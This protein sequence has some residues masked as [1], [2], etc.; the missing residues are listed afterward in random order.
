MESTTTTTAGFRHVPVPPPIS[1]AL[2][3][4][5]EAAEVRAT[6]GQRVFGPIS[7]LWDTFLESDEVRKLPVRLRGPLIALCKEVQQ[8]A[9]QHFDAFLKGSHPPRIA[10]EPTTYAQAA[11]VGETPA[12][13][14]TRKQPTAREQPAVTCKRP[15]ACE[16]P[17]THPTLPP[18]LR[19]R[20][21][22]PDTRLFVRLGAEH[23]ARKAGGYAILCALRKELGEQGHFLKEVQTTKTGFALCTSSPEGLAA[24]ETHT[25]LI[26]QSFGD[27]KVERQDKWTTYRLDNVPRMVR[28]FT[29]LQQVTGSTLR[30]AV[31]DS[32]SQTPTQAVETA[33]S[34]QSYSPSTSWFVSF[35]AESHTPLPKTLRI[36]GVSVIAS[37]MLY[38]PKTIQ[39]SR[40]YHWHNTRSCVRTQRCRVCGSSDHAEEEHTTRC[41][42]AHT[43]PPRCLHC[44]GP[45]VATDLNCPLRPTYKGPKTKSQNVAIIAI[46]KTARKRACAAAKCSRKGPQDTQ[47][48]EPSHTPVRAR[49]PEPT[50]PAVTPTPSV[51]RYK[52]YNEAQTTLFTDRL[53]A[54]K[55]A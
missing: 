54:A 38:K 37:V 33:Q 40:C 31:A 18:L 25:E 16:Q 44:G 10:Q 28:L 23:K 48:R 42:T 5:I 47:M 7:T 22:R 39:C 45:H 21:Q 53:R 36:L 49:S 13:P 6:E 52:S 19:G 3:S 34:A 2:R 46:M 8:T 17:E 24:L 50:S 26:A 4:A 30:A 55:P 12:E 27:C 51:R 35:K 41:S 20:Q 11:A 9:I 1:L 32:V 29:G 15:A 14:V 43:C